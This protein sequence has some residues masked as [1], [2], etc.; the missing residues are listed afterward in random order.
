LAFGQ[1]GLQGRVIHVSVH[2]LQGAAGAQLFEHGG[3][4]E[5]PECV[6]PRRAI[7]SRG[8]NFSGAFLARKARAER[9]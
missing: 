6:S 4:D 2:G 1:L 3:D 5:V 9:R 7:S 8:M